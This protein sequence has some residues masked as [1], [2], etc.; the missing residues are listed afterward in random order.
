MSIVRIADK[1]VY[2]AHVPK[3]AGTAVEL[4]L[5]DRF[6]PLGFRNARFL[7]DPEAM[8]WSKSSPQHID[9]KTLENLLPLSFFSTSFAMVRHPVTR[10]HSV[11]RF[12]RDIQ[13]SLD[14][15]LTFRDWLDTLEE[16]RARNPFYLDNHPR[17]MCD[18]VP[19]GAQI[20]RMEDGLAPVVAWLDGLAG[21][22]DG[23]RKVIFTNG[24][25]QRLSRQ[26]TQPGPGLEVT[27]DVKDRITMLYGMDFQRFAYDIEDIEPETA[28]EHI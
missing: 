1:L 22:Q 7:L 12:Q 6:G 15:K 16:H 4:Y 5:Q 8:R 2:F 9:V 3:C 10:L 14:P 27:E 13:Q 28:K 17:P 20:F 19:E 26:N 25:H 24:Y 18:F 11:F 21:S 23:A